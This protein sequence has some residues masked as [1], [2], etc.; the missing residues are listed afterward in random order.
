MMLVAGPVSEASAIE[1]HGAVAG[2]GV[3]LGDANEEE[4][5][6]DADDAGAEQPPA[7]LQHEVDGSGEAQRARRTR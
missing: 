5:G 6:D 2:L 7:A 1:L 3:V 4:R